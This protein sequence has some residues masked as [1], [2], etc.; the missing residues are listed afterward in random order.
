VEAM[1]CVTVIHIYKLVKRKK[2]KLKQK[3][4]EAC[5]RGKAFA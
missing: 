3:R 1:F 2:E 4:L 5:S